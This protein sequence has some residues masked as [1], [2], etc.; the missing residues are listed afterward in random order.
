M[1]V[2]I[3]TTKKVTEEKEITLP[4]FFTTTE[5]I[6]KRNFAIFNQFMGMSVSER[7]VNCYHA[8]VVAENINKESFQ[9]TT[10]SEFTEAFETTMELIQSMIPV[11]Q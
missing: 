6:G 3:E 7:G 2:Q 4:Y 10:E 5:I 8:S 11:T 1:K 9:E